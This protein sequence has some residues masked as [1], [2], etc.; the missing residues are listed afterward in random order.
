[1]SPPQAVRKTAA[2]KLLS[3]LLSKMVGPTTG[4]PRS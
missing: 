2:S 4:T 3:E 1:L